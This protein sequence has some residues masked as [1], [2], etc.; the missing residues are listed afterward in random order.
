MVRISKP[1][2]IL[3]SS[4]IRILALMV[5]GIAVF[6]VVDG[7]LWSSLL[8]PTLAYR[9]AILFGAT[10]LFGWRG[11]V[12]SQLLFLASFS[13]F[14]GW[15]GAAFITP[16]YLVS[17][18]IG[19]IAA[20][21]LARGE[22]WLLREKST[23]AFLA[24][25]ALA[26][27]LPALLTDAVI[28]VVGP[29]GSPVL[30]SAVDAWLRGAAAILAI[31]PAM[32]VYGSGRL[33]EWAGF[34]PD[35]DR[36]EAISFREVLGLSAEVILWSLTLWITVQFK[37][38]Y[39]LNVTYLTFLPPLSFA[40]FRGM[41]LATLALA[42]NA[43]VGSTLWILLHWASALSALDLRLLI[44]VYS[45]TILVLAAIVDDRKKGREQ[46]QQ[47]LMRES[48]LRES[49][50]YFRILANSAPIMIWVTGPDKLCTF[51]NKPWLD[52]TGCAAD[53]Q[54][55][56]GWADGLHPDDRGSCL[57][58]FEAAF[59]ARRGYWLE[60][61][62]RRADGEYRWILDNGVPLYR[63]GQFAGFI[64]SC[65]DITEQKLAV[66]RLRES[67]SQLAYAQRLAKLGS[68]ELNAETGAMRFSE[69]IL[70]IF[71]LSDLPGTFSACLKYVHTNDRKKLLECSR[72]VLS[73]VTPVEA[74]CRIVL[75][76]GESR[77]VRSI[78][79][80]D[81]NQK[82]ALVR[83][84]GACQ[85]VTDQVEAR[86]RI[87][88]SEQRLKS[89]QELAHV[90]SWYWDLE[91]DRIACSDECKRI[92]G[93]PENYQAT[94]EGLL[95]IIVPRDRERVSREIESSLARGTV[96]STE[97]EIVRPDG[98]LRS[99]TFVSRVLM[100]SEGLPRHVSGACQDV[101][102]MRRTQEEAF[103]RQKLNT[104]GEP[105]ANGIAHDVNNLLGGV[106]AQAELALA[107]LAIRIKLPW[108]RSSGSVK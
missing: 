32:L 42:A 57:S 90:G 55:G 36:G 60:C 92:F 19:L 72:S 30:P 9:P 75:P 59:D 37:A 40:L 63:D 76:G 74:E 22:P 11:L 70:Q 101:T 87:E 89:A 77:V 71:G 83:V 18:V 13:V 14:F 68:F 35:E 39:G 98:E 28:R 29:T 78:V 50:K 62:F 25:A 23:L 105:L 1:R 45:A 102:D 91:A 99:V 54:L 12:W 88:E 17:H 46:V 85:D 69:E 51:V 49:E 15:R 41:R 58:G 53:Q 20:R 106:M 95:G 6:G 81:R 3:Q 84:L 2:S 64:G 7:S 21:R 27:L 82:G 65:L 67:Q 24:G 4:D 8:T 5:G 48:V 43:I 103:A 16:M 108:M 44:T 79:Q 52:F 31:V 26:P 104:L 73:G 94:L 33:K 34:P 38:R 96:C 61:R 107:E 86:N 80:S 47:L 56:Q 93:Q 97:F 10:L 66:E 100:S